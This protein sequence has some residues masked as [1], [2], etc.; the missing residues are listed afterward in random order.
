MKIFLVG[1]ACIGKTTIGKRLADRLECQFFDFD[2][3][4][5]K[6]FSMPV[7]R[8]KARFLTEYSFRKEASKALKRLIEQA[9]DRDYLVAMPPSGLKDSYWRILK[10]LDAVIVVLRD[11][12][13][14]ILDRVTF[15]DDDSNLIHKELT[16]KEKAY[17]LEEIQ[18]DM[19]YFGDSYRRAHHSVNIAGSGIEG[20]VDKIVKCLQ[21]NS[22]IARM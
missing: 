10:K 11:R 5:E 14:N 1:V 19:A 6:Y 7:S 2:E 16:P 9:G 20:S 18:K 13:G 8:I 4:I 15:Y 12:A 3:E 21:D 22:G 17:Y